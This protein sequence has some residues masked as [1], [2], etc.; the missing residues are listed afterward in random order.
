ME[1]GPAT[2][3][4]GFIAGRGKSINPLVNYSNL[5]LKNFS[6]IEHSTQQ[7]TNSIKRQRCE[8][9][10]FS[11]VFIKM[12]ENWR[13]HPT[14]TPRDVTVRLEWG[15]SQVSRINKRQNCSMLHGH[16]LT[17]IC[18]V[19]V[20]DDLYLSVEQILRVLNA[21]VRSKNFLKDQNVLNAGFYCSHY[22][23]N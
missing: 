8:R 12:P 7:G 19:E 22:R 15:E 13:R 6:L 23:I 17:K 10:V 14:L 2:K 18:K 3:H 9:H 16:Q 5:N 21:D 1:D 11:F 4:F 20:T